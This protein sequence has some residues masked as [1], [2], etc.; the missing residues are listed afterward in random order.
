MTVIFKC[1]T[2]EGYSF[3]ILGELLLHNIKIACFVFGQNGISL[4]MMDQ[5]KTI[6]IDLKLQAN[7]FHLYKIDT[8][9]PLNIGVNLSHLYR[10]IKPIKKHD[11]IELFI[12]DENPNLL[13][14]KIV[15]KEGIRVTTSSVQILNTQTIDIDL[16]NEYTNSVL[17][18]STEFQKMCKNLGVIS[19][20][21]QISAS[22]FMIKFANNDNGTMQQSTE[23]GVLDDDDRI[24]Y[25]E[26]YETEQLSKI[27]KLSGLSTTI[28]IFTEQNSPIMFKTDVGK[29]GEISIFLKSKNMK[30]S[31]SL[32]NE[33]D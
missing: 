31:E 21:T 13:N 17:V 16:P 25:D 7:K 33:D 1:K 12:D 9:T 19:P 2:S 15:P 29:L 8:G 14:I 18:P 24:N 6:L 3:K 10:M 27:T 20:N 30:E 4:R 11:S 28:Q 26:E 23:F 32:A 22:R 5:A